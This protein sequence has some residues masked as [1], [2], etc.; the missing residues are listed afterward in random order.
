MAQL[1]QPRIDYGPE[2][3]LRDLNKLVI[4]L[5]TKHVSD[6]KDKEM[7]RVSL[8]ANRLSSLERRRNQYEV[9]F[10]EKQAEISG[11]IGEAQSLSDI[12]QTAS[13]S[14]IENITADLYEEPFK[15]YEQAMG[16]TQKQINLL[17]PQILTSMDKLAKLSQAEAFLTKGVGATYTTGAG[18]KA[19]TWGPEDLTQALFM[20]KFYPGAGVGTVPA[21][22][23]EIG[24]YFERHKVDPTFIAGKEKERKTEA[25][26]EES[27]V[28]AR[29][30][31]DRAIDVAARA[32]VKAE[33]EAEEFEVRM[34]RKALPLTTEINKS[35]ARAN[36]YNP[37]IK[38]AGIGMTFA[39]IGYAD[40][41]SKTGPEKELGQQTFEVEAFRIGLLFNP[42]AKMTFGIPLD[43]KIKEISTADLMDM[44][45]GFMK[46]AGP[47]RQRTLE[48]RRIGEKIF[49]QN[50]PDRAY[51]ELDIKRGQKVPPYNVRDELIATAYKKYREYSNESSDKAE[52]Y[53]AD[54]KWILGIDIKWEGTL[55]P[56]LREFF[57]VNA[58]EGTLGIKGGYDAFDFED[59]NDREKKAAWKL[60]EM[61][62]NKYHYDIAEDKWIASIKKDAEGKD[63][64]IY[65]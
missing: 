48:I 50:S 2:D 55:K 36:W 16:V 6:K 49:F 7:G 30:A 41:I 45:Q 4:T 42:E 62:K 22:P 46:K 15:Y 51:K 11:Y 39:A 58:L 38:E 18:E 56:K 9:A 35:L 5:A 1:R 63:I 31:E 20:E 54:V 3:T 61:V 52:E 13:G 60:M 21:A 65:E 24:A 44:Y 32:K 34:G 40:S 47:K 43:Q 28:A 26:T 33:Q 23:A 37:Q 14:S 12:Y 29:A 8:A 19:E 17:N 53:A 10:L 57:R 27:R 25:F 59:L 64:I